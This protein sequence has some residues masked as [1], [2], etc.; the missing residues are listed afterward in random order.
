LTWVNIAITFTT[1]KML[2]EYMKLTQK[3]IIALKGNKRAKAR[4]QLNMDKSDYTV[5]RW[6]SENDENGPLT[7]ATALRIVSEELKLTT[8]EILEEVSEPERA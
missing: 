3:A 5:N 2:N 8:D 7:T 4:L 6:I 1:V